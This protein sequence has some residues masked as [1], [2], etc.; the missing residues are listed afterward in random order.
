MS[1]G[2]GT[3][4]WTEQRRLVEVEALAHGLQQRLDNQSRALGLHAERLK[5][6]ENPQQKRRHQ[7]MTEWESETDNGSGGYW[8]R[9]KVCGMAIRI[10]DALLSMSDL[11]TYL[12]EPCSAQ[13]PW[14]RFP[15]DKLFTRG[16]RG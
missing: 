13:K 12:E 1:E 3:L 4:R 5:Q 6:L 2:D 9:C 8:I 15:T 14:E 7:L 11:V 16:E 10:A